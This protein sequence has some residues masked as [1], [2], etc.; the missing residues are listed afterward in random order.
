MKIKFSKPPT[1]P[2]EYNTL[3]VN[4]APA[5]R[6][7]SKWRFR[8]VLILFL[9]LF[10]VFGGYLIYKTV[11]NL[12]FI[13]A[14]GYLI[15]NQIT[16]KAPYDGYIE[17]IKK[18]GEK[19]SKGE[20]IAKINNQV[21]ENQYKELASNLQQV[22]PVTPPKPSPEMLKSA[23]ELYEYRLK[24]YKEILSLREKGAATNA[25]VSNA[26]SQLNSAEISYLQIKSSLESNNVTYTPPISDNVRLNELKSILESLI[27]KAPQSGTIALDFVKEGEL[28]S[29]DSDLISI[30]IDNNIR[31]EAFLDPDKSKYV[32]LNKKARV[33]FPDGQSIEA[34]IVGLKAQTQKIPPVLVSPFT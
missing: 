17:F 23:K 6:P 24:T 27:V 3:K 28:V 31:I 30:Q 32:V 20:I 2:D 21:L 16:I 9:L 25:E 10:I 12:F 34:R 13:N 1:S 15:Y 4:Y 19:V 29:K 14:P 33:I 26:L 22:K 8:I 18:P 11:Y 5:K 7:I